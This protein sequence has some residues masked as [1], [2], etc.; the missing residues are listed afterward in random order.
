M[1]L[2]ELCLS[3]DFGG[4]EIFFRDFARWLAGR[5]D[6]TLH[7]GLREKSRLAGELAP[8]ERPT[9]S[10]PDSGGKLPLK[11]ARALA[12][13]VRDAQIDA[14]HMHW[15]DD[16][17]LVALAKRW[18][19]RKVRV[20][21]SRHMDLPGSKHDPYHRFI[22]SAV[23]Q[24]HA[25]TRALA[26]QAAAHLSLPRERIRQV[27]LGAHVPSSDTLESRAQVRSRLGWGDAFTVGVVGR[28]SEYKGQHLLIDAIWLLA[29][30]GVQVNGVIAGHAMEE[31][32]LESLRHRVHQAGLDEQIRFFGFQESPHA[33]IR[34]LDAL[35]LTTVKETFGL[36]LVEAMLLGVPVI[37][38][39]A[40]GVPEIIVHGESGLLFEPENSASL[41]GAIE[42]LHSDESLRSRLTASGRARAEREFNR[43]TQNFKV[44]ELLR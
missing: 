32:Y 9:F 14:I 39:N 26:S 3:P 34:A 41:A 38:S 36:V 30:R 17:P 1:N 23:D 13:Y 4:L 10:L 29:D 11:R 33:L 24:F 27:Y 6:V 40:G 21:H 35:A 12:R 22:Y 31:D 8:L 44:L 7:L 16:L 37:G 42:S 5:E 43:D 20:I 18:S 2:L 19:G 15:K 28:I 25:I